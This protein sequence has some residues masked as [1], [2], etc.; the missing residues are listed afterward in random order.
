METNSSSPAFDPSNYSLS[1][2][3]N[4]SNSGT[5]Q[6]NVIEIEHAFSTGE[7]S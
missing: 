7:F 3:T 6:F 4:S 2:P 1:S 5:N